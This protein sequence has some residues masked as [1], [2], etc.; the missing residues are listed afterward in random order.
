MTTKHRWVIIFHQFCPFGDAAVSNRREGAETCLDARGKSNSVFVNKT[1]CMIRC[2][3]QMK[4]CFGIPCRGYAGLTLAACD[5]LAVWKQSFKCTFKLAGCRQNF[6]KQNGNICTWFCYHS[7]TG[8]DISSFIDMTWYDLTFSVANNF[9]CHKFS[10]KLYEHYSVWCINVFWFHGIGNF[11]K[12]WIEA[13]VEKN[14]QHEYMTFLLRQTGNAAH[15][16]ITR[17]QV[18]HN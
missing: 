8:I 5:F 11:R 17:L 9:I 1:T 7:M 18:C 14:H 6:V 12:H 16:L 10:W 13:G 4:Q 2:H 3:L 15:Y